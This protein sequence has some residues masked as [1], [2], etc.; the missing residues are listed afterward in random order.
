MFVGGGEGG[1]WYLFLL[2]RSVSFRL[3]TLYFIFST[4]WNL[5]CFMELNRTIHF[6]HLVKSFT[7]FFFFFL[8]QRMSLED[9]LTFLAVWRLYSAES[10]GTLHRVVSI[11]LCFLH[12]QLSLQW[13]WDPM[14]TA[15][16]FTMEVQAS[17]FLIQILH[18]HF[19]WYFL[20]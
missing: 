18:F 9:A 6:S 13:I 3:C 12:R 4:G 15:E 20:E 5:K 2:Q 11:C 14:G 17:E 1:V 16:V 8:F 7:I 19:R 10:D